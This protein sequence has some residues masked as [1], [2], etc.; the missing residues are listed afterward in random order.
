[1]KDASPEMMS[2]FSGALERSSADERAAYLAAACGTDAE[3]RARIEALLRAHEE[4]GGFLPLK[5]EVP[6]T[7]AAV[8]QPTVTERPGTIIGPYK[9]MEQ[10]GEGGMGLVFVAEQQHPVRRKVALKVIK[11][12]MDTRQVI[13]R[14]EAER[15]ALALMDHPNIAKVLDGGTTGGEPGGVSPGRP[16]FV[17]ELVK[18]LPIT[19]YCDQNQVPIR[20]RLGLF[21]NV[22][23]AVQHAHQKG[24]IHRDIK[25]SNVLVMSHD[26]KPVVRVIDFGIAKA[27]GQQLTD[28]TIYTEFTQLVGTP[29]YMSPEQAGQSG[30]DVDTRSD[31][32]SLGVLL[33]ELLT[34]TTPFDKERLKEAGYDEMRRIIREEEPPR[35]ST[36]ISTLGPAAMT[37]SANRKSHPK[38]LSRLCRGEPDWIVMKALEKDR[39]RRYETASAF[40]ADVQ[41]YLADEPVQACPPSV[42][43]RLRK[44]GRRHKTALAVAGLI[45]FFIVLFGGGGGWFLGDRAARKAG[46][47]ERAT[48]A[49]DDMWSALD[50]E[51]LPEATAA[52]AR[53]EAVVAAAE[54]NVATRARVE[55]A[56]RLVEL[57]AE[58]D[59]ARF[60]SSTAH[61]RVWYAEQE[62]RF[63]KIFVGQGIDVDALSVGEAAE[64]IKAHSLHRQ[65]A[66]ALDSWAN[67]RLIL[68][69]YEDQRDAEWWQRLLR[70]AAKADADEARNRVRTALL[71]TRKR[72]ALIDPDSKTLQE[73]ADSP[74]AGRLPAPTVIVL[75]RALYWGGDANR[76]ELAIRVL[77]QAHAHQ[78]DQFGLNMTLGIY[79]ALLPEPRAEQALAYL[80]AARAIRPQDRQVPAVIADPILR[81]LN[82]IEECLP[83]LSAAIEMYPDDPM[84]WNN[85]GVAYIH[86]EEWDRTIVDCSKAIAV[87]PNFSHP[88]IT[89]SNAYHNKKMFDHALSDAEQA[90]KLDPKEAKAWACRGLAHN[91]LGKWE[92][93]R[94]DFTCSIEL[95]HKWTTAWAGRG[96]AWAWE[97]R[98]KAHGALKKYQ[99][100]TADYT[101][102]IALDSADLAAFTRRGVLFGKVVERAKRKLAESHEHRGS[103]YSQHLHDYDKAI[104]DFDRAIQLDRQRT[105]AWLGRALV[106]L[107]RKEWQAA[108]QDYTQVLQ[109]ET[110]KAKT[111][112][113]AI[114]WYQR[115]FAHARLGQWK[116]AVDDHSRALSLDPDNADAWID[117]AG[118]YRESR[119][120]E[121]AVADYSEAIK[122]KPQDAELWAVRGAI[123]CEQLSQYDKAIEDFSEAVRLK[124]DYVE[125]WYNLGCIY[126]EQHQYGKA[127]ANFSQALQLRP[128]HFKAWMRRG[129]IYGDVL[130]QYDKAIKDFSDAVKLDPKSAA[131][132]YEL[133]N[134][135]R[136]KGDL[137][138]AKAAYRRAIAL[139]PEHFSAR[140]NLG[141]LLQNQGEFREAL[142][143]LRLSQKL[144]A[145]DPHW[146]SFM[147]QGV[148]KCERLIELDEK[149]PAF[150]EGKIT[151]SNAERIELAR[152]C[153]YKRL[154]RAAACFYGEAFAKEQKLADDLGAWH[155]YSAACAAAL[156]GSGVGK[157]ADRLDE[158]EKAGLRDQALAWLQAELLLRG[159]QLASG[160][161]ADRAEVQARLRW[162]LADAD[163]AGVRGP[164]ALAKLPAAERQLWQRLW[165]D[166][167]LMLK[168]A[169]GKT[170]PAMK[171]NAR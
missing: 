90:V 109:R 59:E 113:M 42:G 140:W 120:Y 118:V 39:N 58:F 139:Q 143:E 33:Y 62:R 157:D 71:G 168:H 95:D 145:K 144:V 10:I 41:R 22:C 114:I 163:L 87:D 80:H 47:D 54:T 43:Y 93:A 61:P 68:W 69:P 15:Q 115:G 37:V 136:G 65:L 107:Q 84:T 8:E 75:A 24:I 67:A 18:G 44:F 46:I 79:L 105:S 40:A 82:R 129:A 142:Q 34:G 26:G 98:A 148:K 137:K 49:L 2:L 52:V 64:R 70:V 156:A 171:S 127:V 110:E 123:Y 112:E 155:R 117:R 25:P 91:G 134:A 165:E 158:K 100:A 152:L 150:Q 111:P 23:E 72:K 128:S 126:S 108:I 124:K 17:M 48:R 56:R 130:K 97:G 83:I 96:L 76:K 149:L 45:L 51:R 38:Q 32:Y 89:R 92:E 160:K 20:E 138:G 7:G 125:V 88:W 135:L 104:E 77:K 6:V 141:Q 74:D 132:H 162:W 12:G 161:P 164:E 151:P 55:E 101:K 19:D 169:E 170:V 60:Y 133:G 78:P 119:Q 81:S 154:H 4:A 131:A 21:L 153:R 121:N 1:M 13:A 106:H 146:A 53:A 35:P 167:A 94:A 122:R 31:I 66:L 86:L 27:I 11:P 29:L 50:Q 30:L 116:H 73:M 28:K 9:L 159:K 14:F 57:M 5:L 166:V 147:A 99:E 3:L 63:R 102:A 85:R 16:Y 36:R 103:V